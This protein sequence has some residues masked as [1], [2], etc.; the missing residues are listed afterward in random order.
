MWHSEE[1][2]EASH[3]IKGRREVEQEVVLSA[4]GKRVEHRS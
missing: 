3:R 4:G 2:V 1:D